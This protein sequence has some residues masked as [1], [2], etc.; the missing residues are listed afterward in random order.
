[1]TGMRWAI[2]IAGVILLVLVV[3]FAADNLLGLWLMH[4]FR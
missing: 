1:M 2:L 4:H 3:I